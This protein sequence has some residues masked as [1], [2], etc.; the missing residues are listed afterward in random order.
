MAK[1]NISPSATSTTVPFTL[2]LRNLWLGGSLDVTEYFLNSSTLAG[3]NGASATVQYSGSAALAPVSPYPL[4]TSNVQTVTLTLNAKTLTYVRLAVHIDGPAALTL[5]EYWNGTGPS[6]LYTYTVSNPWISQWIN[7]TMPIWI[8][9]QQD[10]M[11]NNIYAVMYP[12]ASTTSAM[13]SNAPS[14]NLKVEVKD[15]TAAVLAF[16]SV[17][18]SPTWNPVCDLNGDYKIDIKDIAMIARQ[19]GY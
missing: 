10:I 2:T 16:G 19:F 12:T 8:T 3:V 14:P 15:I 17:P 6:N 7:V 5:N 11:G 13:T 1:I 9:I 18:G 4:G